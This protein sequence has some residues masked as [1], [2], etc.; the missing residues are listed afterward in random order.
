MTSDDSQLVCPG[1][2]HVG[3]PQH[4]DC[5]QTL[6]KGELGRYKNTD[7]FYSLSNTEKHH[8]LQKNK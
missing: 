2:G 4:Q 3:V 1:H 8:S 7:V 6:W 5:I